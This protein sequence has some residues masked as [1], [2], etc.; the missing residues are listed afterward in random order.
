MFG[1]DEQPGIYNMDYFVEKQKKNIIG[2]KKL[3]G[4]IFPFT[5]KVRIWKN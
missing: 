4:A 1:V 3:A 2:Q 5:S